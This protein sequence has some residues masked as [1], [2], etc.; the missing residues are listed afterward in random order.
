[1]IPRVANIQPAPHRDHLTW[2]IFLRSQTHALP[3]ADFFETNTL[4]GAQLSVL[5]IIE[6]ATRRIRILGATAHPTAVWTTQ[7]ARNWSW[8]CR[9]SAPP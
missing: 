1:L 5:V 3:A 7:M 9:R 2:A 8:T 6:H 4:T